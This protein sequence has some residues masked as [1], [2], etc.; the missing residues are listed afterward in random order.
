MNGLQTL[1]EAPS[2]AVL[3]TYRRDG[4]AHVS[5][6]WFRYQGVAFEVVVAKSDVKLRHLAQDPRAVLMI[7]ETIAPFR[8]VKVRA[9]VE[10]DDSHVDEV[11]HA[12]SSR[13]L[14]P[15]TAQAFVAERGEGVVVRLSASAAKVWDLSGILPATTRSD[16]STER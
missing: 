10:V 6:V 1:L 14:G 4:S 13:Y 11:R 8:G 16:G 2:P 12:I 3:I 5:P 9:D 7:F 15:E